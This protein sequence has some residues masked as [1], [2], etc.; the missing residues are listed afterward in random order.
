M[1][2]TVSPTKPG[3]RKR[4]TADKNIRS[5]E[6]TGLTF[7]GPLRGRAAAKRL[8]AMGTSPAIAP[9]PEGSRGWKIAKRALKITGG[10]VAGGGL[11]FSVGGESATAHILGIIKF[12]L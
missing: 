8:P 9:T 6:S 1:P 10:S 11:I 2:K 7:G 12:L 3:Q 5:A 4:K